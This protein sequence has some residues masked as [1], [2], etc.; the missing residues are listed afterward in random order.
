MLDLHSSLRTLER[1]PNRV[2]FWDS[3]SRL[4]GF[5]HYVTTIWFWNR[6]APVRCAHPLF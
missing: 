5:L 2:S 4:S 6:Y 3:S 1:A